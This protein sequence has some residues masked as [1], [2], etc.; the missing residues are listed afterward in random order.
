MNLKKTLRL[1][2]DKELEKFKLAVA[3]ASDHIVITDPEGIILYANKGVEEI[4]GFTNKE[5]L[6]KKAGTKKLWGGL[7]S[8][9]FY[10]NFWR[11]IKIK[12][13]PFAGEVLNKRKNG[14]RYY[15]NLKVSPILNEE[16][17]VLF[18]VGI[19]RDIT[20][21][22]EVDRMKT[23]FISLVSHQLKTPLTAI[24]WYI[25]LMEADTE[26]KLNKTQKANLNMVSEA[27]KRM[28]SLVNGLLNISRIESGRIIIDP[29]ET[30]LMK[31]V[32]NLLKELEE[33]LKAKNQ[34]LKFTHTNNLSNVW[35]DPDLLS[36]VYTN[37]LTNAIKYSPVDSMIEL[38]IKRM[39]NT[40]VSRVKDHGYGI[41]KA[42]QDKVFEKFY[43]G[44]NIVKTVVDG[45]GLGLYLVKQIVETMKGEISFKSE[46]KKGTTFRVELPLKGLE[47]K[48]GE[49]KL[50]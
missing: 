43:R 2:Q 27:N 24:R 9:T 10:Q 32:E 15:A 48:A 29:R 31:L 22:R 49:V 19:E 12:K 33:K 13:K 16:K 46:E 11:E 42:E 38:S 17:E 39:G 35:T 44:S 5:V 47:K 14:E 23:E 50:S 6:H 1:S 37:L 4:T 8:K 40:L 30:D 26:N 34:K 3:G 36:N 21:E 41:P 25:E 28:I 45:N 18:F 20:K 7:M